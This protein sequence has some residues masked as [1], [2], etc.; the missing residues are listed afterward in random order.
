[1]VGQSKAG[2][3]FAQVTKA[4]GSDVENK[5][6]K[7]A[8]Y[9][10][11]QNTLILFGPAGEDEQIELP[12]ASDQYWSVKTIVERVDASVDGLLDVMYDL[13]APRE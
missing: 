12:D 1:M 4:T 5:A 3:V 6:E 8:D 11:D 7:L 13:P 9:E 10:S 2:R